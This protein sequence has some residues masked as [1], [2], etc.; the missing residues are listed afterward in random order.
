MA[1]RILI[2]DD[3][4]LMRAALR[5]SVTQS[6]PDADIVEASRFEEEARREREPGRGVIRER[7]T[8]PWARTD[9][10][11][12]AIRKRRPSTNAGPKRT[13]ILVVLLVPALWTCEPP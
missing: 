8:L 12:R 10:S 4:P 11:A 7:G 5:Q 6:L 3:H 13:R 1:T 9:G 2:A